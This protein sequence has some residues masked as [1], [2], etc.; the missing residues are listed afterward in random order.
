MTGITNTTMDQNTF[1]EPSISRD[2][3]SF[4]VRISENRIKI[5]NTM[6]IMIFKILLINNV[7]M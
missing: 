1:I 4:K 5:N 3:I 6:T 2:N 7:C